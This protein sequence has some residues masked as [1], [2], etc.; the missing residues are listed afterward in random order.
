MLRFDSDYMETAHPRIL[1]KLTEINFDK[2]TSYGFDVY[3]ESAKDKIRKECNCPDAL[4]YFLI[5][6]TQTNKVAIDALIEGYEAVICASTGHIATHETGAIESCG[7]KVITLE[8][9]NGKLMPETLEG[10]MQ[11]F[12]AD[13]NHEHS[14][15]PGLVYISFPT[16]YGTI[17]SR[18]E[19]ESLRKICDSYSL[20]LYVD[21]A[22]LG[23][24][25]MSPV[26]DITLPELARLADG[27]YIGGTKVG[28][29]LGE[30]L[31]IPNPDSV[32]KLFVQIK[33]HGALLAKGWV[34][35]VQF[36]TLFTD[37]LY[38]EIS[39]NAIDNA[40]YLRDELKNLGYE[41]FLDSPTNQQFVVVD[42]EKLDLIKDKVGYGFWHK[43][44]GRTVIRFATS[45]ATEKSQVDELIDLLG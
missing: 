27:F 14:A 7:H 13:K 40:M 20:R 6:G 34:A 31:V 15:Q 25:L 16:E 5:G 2:N 17:Y 4:V 37:G 32:K 26:C 33:R 11:S 30:A 9:E 12:Y 22:R 24:G 43:L 38:F 28:A 29:M 39:K 35:G 36:D 10:Y 42:D 18:A 19:L 21:G 23:Y 8:G 45:W 3:T 44:D 41:M 1:Q